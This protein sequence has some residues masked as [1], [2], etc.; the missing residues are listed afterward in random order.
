M[1]VNGHMADMQHV[2]MDPGQGAD[3]TFYPGLVRAAAIAMPEYTI[4]AQD[5]WNSDSAITE[6]A[7]G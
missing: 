4:I 3:S 2:A 6:A 7:E 1:F 5:K